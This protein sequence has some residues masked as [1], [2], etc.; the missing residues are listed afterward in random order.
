MM[1]VVLGAVG[2]G[3]ASAQTALAVDDA[4][5]SDLQEALT[6]GRVTSSDLTRAYLARIE[7][8]DRLGP[9]LKSVRVTNPD[10]L[11]IA[12]GLDG[13][14]P[15]ASQPL[16]GLPILVMG[17]E[18]D[19]VSEGKRLKNLAHA[20]REARCQ[21]LQLNIYPQARHELFNETNRDSVTADVLVWLT[22]AVNQRRPA[23][24]E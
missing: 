21:N 20:L 3:T 14:K 10:A 5:L 1:P 16:A 23:R 18:C 13:V 22:Q 9:G 6:Q 19:P 17:G 2:A 8:Y 7:A 15:S 24:F 4:S 12:A 11:T